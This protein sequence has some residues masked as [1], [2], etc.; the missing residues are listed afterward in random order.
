MTEHRKFP[1]VPD[2]GDTAPT[3]SLIERAVK[4]FDLTSFAPPPVP[5]QLAAAPPL[6]KSRRIKATQVVQAE[7]AAP[8]A[9]SGET[10]AVE[11]VAK[12]APA[13]ELVASPSREKCASQLN[14]WAFATPSIASICAI[15]G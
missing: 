5:E 11:I 8:Q 1:P 6:Q 12:P 9:P 4:S 14:S 3:G 15:R 13:A 2:E 7:V 10:V